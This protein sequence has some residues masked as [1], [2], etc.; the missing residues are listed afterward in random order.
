MTKIVLNK[1]V[2][3]KNNLKDILNKKE[4]GIGDWCSGN[5]FL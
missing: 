2:I 4:D 1:R 3:L 5:N